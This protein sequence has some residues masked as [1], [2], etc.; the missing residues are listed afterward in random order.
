MHTGMLET[1]RKIFTFQMRFDSSL[2][3]KHEHL[4]NK[5]PQDKKQ[6]TLSE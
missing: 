4:G 1:Y 3:Q 6:L 2:S 5:I